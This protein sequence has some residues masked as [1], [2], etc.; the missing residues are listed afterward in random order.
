[1]K[2][3]ETFE[4]AGEQN[5]YSATLTNSCF[6]EYFN[7]VSIVGSWLVLY[8][9]LFNLSYP[10]FLRMVRDKYNA[11]LFG[12]IGYI[13]FYFLKREDCDKFVKECNKRF[14]EWTGA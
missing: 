5:R 4:A 1:M 13:A 6:F 3:F 12:K 7:G 10:D 8:A 9:R 11:T 2:A 14:K